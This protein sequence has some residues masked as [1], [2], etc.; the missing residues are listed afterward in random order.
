LRVCLNRKLIRKEFV[1]RFLELEYEIDEGGL[2]AGN[3]LDD[4]SSQIIDHLVSTA[5]TSFLHQE[6][7]VETIFKVRYC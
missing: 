1:N 7:R 5:T 4:P 3:I 6:S 2:T